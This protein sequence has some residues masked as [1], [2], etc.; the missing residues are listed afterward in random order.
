[1]LSDD[2]I[3]SIA[4]SVSVGMSEN[5]IFN[6]VIK[7]QVT[8]DRQIKQVLM[9]IENRYHNLEKMKL[10]KRKSIAE[11]KRAQKDLDNSSDDIDKELHQIDI[12]NIQLDVEMWDRKISQLEYELN[13]FLDYLKSTVESEEDLEKASQYSVEEER[14]YWI[15]RLGKQA[16]LDIVCSGRIGVGNLDS[17][18]MMKEEDQMAILNVATQYSGLMNVSMNK[19]QQENI[20]Y[21]E[22]FKDSNSWVVPTFHGI[23]EK[24]EIP[25][26]EKFKDEQSELPY[27][28]PSNQSES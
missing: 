19:I 17:I 28:Q 26:L 24:L 14:K 12:E 5:Q 10:S 25:L 16:A 11:Q 2:K 23:E 21:L 13:C 6:Y 27:L 18:A 22:R 3:K 20:K 4:K 7:S 9:E 1:M 8:G 15:A